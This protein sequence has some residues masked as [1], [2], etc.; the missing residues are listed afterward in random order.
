MNERRYGMALTGAVCALM[1]VAAAGRAESSAPRGGATRWLEFA[2]D[3]PGHHEP[4]VGHSAKA[5]TRPST[6]PAEA[7]AIG[8]IWDRETLTGGWFGL[9]RTLEDYGI[10]L[11]IGLTQIYQINARGHLATHRRAGRHTGSYDLELNVDMEKLAGLK[12]GQVYALA[13]GGWSGGI[14]DSSVGSFFGA[15]ADAF[16]DYAIALTQLYYEQ[17]LLNDRVRFRIGKID[18]TGGFECRGCVA[19]F[20]GNA[21]ANDETFQFLNGAL[22]N[23]PTIPFPDYGLGAVLYVE[24]VDGFYLSAGG[25]DAQADF[26]ETGFNT[27]FHREDQFFSIYEAGAT[28]RLPSANGWLQGAYRVGFWLDGVPRARFKDGRTRSD[29]AGFYLSF[30]QML[31]REKEGADVDDL[32]AQGL[33]AFARYGLTDGDVNEV[34]TFWSAGLQYRGPLPGRDEDILAFGAAQGCLSKEAAFRASHETA[35]EVYYS[36]RVTGWLRISPSA[37]YVFNAGGDGSD[38]VVVGMR[39]QMAF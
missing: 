5:A 36:I 3:A 35:M 2:Q 14:D 32:S 20:D 6:R 37:Q 27:T 17:A 13:E 28:P 21:F 11:N 10:A 39:A 7:E 16:G 30:D 18:L 33:G 1:T 24:P 26:R 25:A 4:R 8:S 34:R 15:N 19:S 31:Y 12:G 23:N 9:A 29:D 22:V 38:A